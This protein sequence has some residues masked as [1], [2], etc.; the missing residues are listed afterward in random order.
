M[1]FDISEEDRAGLPPELLAQLSKPAKEREA[2]VFPC[3]H[4]GKK[5]WRVVQHPGTHAFQIECAHCWS[6]G[7]GAVDRANAIELWN[8]R[9]PEEAH[10]SSAGDS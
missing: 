10:Q 3:P 1:E 5:W 9:A 6:R 2:P 7:P 8:W 4:C